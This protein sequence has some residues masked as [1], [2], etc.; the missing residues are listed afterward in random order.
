MTADR[1]GR[2]LTLGDTDRPMHDPP[3]DIRGRWIID[4]NGVEI[5]YIDALLVDDQEREVRFLRIASSGIPRGDTRKLL[6]PVEAV[7]TV[8]DEQVHIDQT[9]ERVTSSPRYDPYLSYDHD[10]YG[11]LYRHYGFTP[12]WHER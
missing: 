6:L 9:G 5:G 1:A 11:A 2:L 8:D 7:I 12:Y 3:G 10:Y 4:P